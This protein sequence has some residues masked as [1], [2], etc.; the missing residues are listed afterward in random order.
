MSTTQQPK[1]PSAQP[2]PKLAALLAKLTPAE[3]E[4]AIKMAAALLNKR[5]EREAKGNGVV[6]LTVYEKGAGAGTTMD[7][8]RDDLKGDTA[9]LEP[10]ND[11]VRMSLTPE[12]GLD[13]RQR[14]Q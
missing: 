7:T 12:N 13:D 9:R 3:R 14:Q 11:S 5:A 8:A 6:D 4:Q 10:G 2:S 1:K